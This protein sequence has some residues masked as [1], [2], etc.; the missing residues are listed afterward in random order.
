MKQIVRWSLSTEFVSSPL[1]LKLARCKNTVKAACIDA[2]DAI[3][4]KAAND[5]CSSEIKT[6]FLLSGRNPYDV[7]KDCKGELGD[8]LCYPITKYVQFQTTKTQ[9]TTSRAVSAYLDLKEVRELLGV[10]PSVGKF[11]VANWS[12][13][14]AFES[15]LDRF[16]QTQHWVAMLLERDVRVLIYVGEYDWICNW[17]G[18]E[19]FTLAMEWS[20]QDSFVA[21]KLGTWTSNSKIAGKKRSAGPLTFLTLKGAGHMVNSCHF[22]RNNG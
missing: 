1:P 3:D 5:F 6:P 14:Q 22:S 13:S 18:N 4:C 2:F 12:V 9:L 21:E 15:T 19:A 8:T 17:I 11:Q 7:S 20:G 10:D 16:Y